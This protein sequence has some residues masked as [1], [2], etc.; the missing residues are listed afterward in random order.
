MQYLIFNTKAAAQSRTAQIATNLGC[1]KHPDDVTREWFGVIEHPANIPQSA[2]CIPE[3][4][5]DKLT[6]QERNI[7]KDEAFMRQ[8]G[9]FGNETNL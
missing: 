7:L 8:Q 5:E 1:G 3:G 6:L 4:E 2:L 9:W